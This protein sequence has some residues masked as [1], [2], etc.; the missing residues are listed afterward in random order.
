MAVPSRGAGS[1]ESLSG[2]PATME[3]KDARELIDKLWEPENSPHQSFIGMSGSGKSYLVI[4]GILRPLCAM[5]RVLIVDTK[6]N[7]PLVSSI[8]IPCEN[9]PP[10]KHWATPRHRKP[11]DHWHRLVVHD[12]FNS[13]GRAKAK[14]QVHKALERIY[15]EGNWVVFLDEL[16]DLGGRQQPN[17]G[18]TMHIDEIYRKGRSRHISIL[19]T[20]QAPRNVP[21]SFYD[22]P[23]FHWISRLGDEEKQK[24]LGEIGGLPKAMRPHLA[25]LQKR[26]WLMTADGGEHIFTTTVTS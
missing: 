6:R 1:R 14:A 24:R 15:K 2:A 16:Q 3:W 11:F 25:T 5:D 21:T 4:N 8:G 13:D 22:Q 17:L 19:A 26:Q 18:L 23:S 10:N 20:T 9:I 12:Q 7:D